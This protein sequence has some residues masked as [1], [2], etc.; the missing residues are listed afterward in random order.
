MR[1]RS[2]CYADICNRYMAENM[3]KSV[4]ILS[5]LAAEFL[6]FWLII[7]L[8]IFPQ[9]EEYKNERVLEVFA[10][11][12]GEENY[13]EFTEEY[14]I[15]FMDEIPFADED[16]Y[17]DIFPFWGQVRIRNSTDEKMLIS[18]CHEY[19]H[20]VTLRDNLTEDEYYISLYEEHEPIYS[21]RCNLSPLA[22]KS[23]DEFC[24]CVVGAGYYN[25]EYM[26]AGKEK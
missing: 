1:R 23:I 6:V 10:E 16:T 21:G 12:I 25:A 18:L 5:A 13:A 26:K 15:I 9:G 17:G 8:L 22:Y 3:K 11:M 14:N 20:Y 4:L 7:V 24:A 19:G 2:V